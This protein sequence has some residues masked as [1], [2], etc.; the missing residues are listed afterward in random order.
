MDSQHAPRGL[1]AL[2]GRHGRGMFNLVF[3]V[4]I[5]ISLA[6]AVQSYAVKPYVIPSGSMQPTL[7]IGQRVLVDRFSERIGSDPKIGDVVVFHPPLNAVPEEQPA[8]GSLPRCEEPA[9]EG[10]VCSEPGGREAE[11]AYIKRVV[12]GPG[13]RIRVVDGIPL[14]NGERVEGDFETV[15]CRTG[16]GCDFPTTVTVPAGHYFMMGDNR[17]NSEDSRFWGP[18]PRSWI[19]GRAFATYWPPNRLGGL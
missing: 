3:T 19:L 2:T 9:E 5:A 13:D 15:P 7:E 12:A 6:L 11:Q 16:S 10:A 1:A 8:D 17:P 4:A 18:V 14:V